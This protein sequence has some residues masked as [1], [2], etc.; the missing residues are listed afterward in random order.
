MALTPLDS[1]LDDVEAHVFPTVGKI[2]SQGI[3]H[4]SDPAPHI[5][6]PVVWFEAA[7]LREQVPEFQSNSLVIP[8]ADKIH[9]PRRDHLPAP[10]SHV[11][12][13]KCP[14][15]ERQQKFPDR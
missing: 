1:L 5:Q 14:H 3:R 7:V 13:I 4:S 11:G 6:Y 8:I 15:I 12:N 9:G 2:I 10:R